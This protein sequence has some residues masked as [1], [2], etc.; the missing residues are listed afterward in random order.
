M[1]RA[2]AAS[3]STTTPLP[4]RKLVTNPSATEDRRSPFFFPIVVSCLVSGAL[5]SGVS[6]AMARRSHDGALVDRLARL[7]QQ[8]ADGRG[9]AVPRFLVE[10]REGERASVSEA[11]AA[12]SREIAELRGKND[13]DDDS[14]DAANAHQMAMSEDAGQRRRAIRQL[15]ELAKTDPAARALLSKLLA[16]PDPRV[17]RD[18]IEALARVGDPRAIGEI[19]ALLKDGDGRVRSRAAK[20]LSEMAGD[21]KDPAARSA[22]AQSLQTLLGDEKPGVRREAVEALRRIGGQDAVPGLLKA[23]NDRNFEVQEQ[24][25]EGLGASKDPAAIPALR[26][27]Y[28]D[29]SGPNALEAAVAMK[30]LGDPS[31][32]AKEAERLKIVLQQGGTPEDKRE[33]LELLVEHSPQDARTLLETARRDPSESVR[34]HAQELLDRRTK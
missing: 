30:R 2:Q 31:A 25:V 9:A 28:G 18:A 29:G 4:E 34:R 22:A 7:E 23:A 8:L 33:A 3:H 26:Q 12:L 6:Y 13:G 21:T 1:T 20:T 11:V 32:F 17:R 16:D 27:A 15:R 14:R 19:S 5:A 24:A 10:P